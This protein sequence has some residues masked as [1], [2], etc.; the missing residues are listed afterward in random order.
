M[1]SGF[2][3]SE[4]TAFK[5]VFDKSKAITAQA[6][7]RGTEPGIPPL[8]VLWIAFL[9][10]DPERHE[11]TSGRGAGG[12]TEDAMPSVE[13]ARRR[14]HPVS[15]AER[16]ELSQPAVAPAESQALINKDVLC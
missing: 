11:T 6:I 1:K 14:H 5:N 4:V 15:F 7:A 9:Q 16:S 10:N 8:L 12:R 13:D 3:G 2:C